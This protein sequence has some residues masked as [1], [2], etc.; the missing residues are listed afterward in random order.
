MTV[1]LFND[2]DPFCC[3]KEIVNYGQGG[4]V[5]VGAVPK[6]YSLHRMPGWGKGS[7]GYH[8]DDGKWEKIYDQDPMSTF[9]GMDFFLISFLDI[10]FVNLITEN[11]NATITSFRYL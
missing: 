9:K 4:A 6:G 2:R 11:E 1:Q 3:F 5:G 7:I 8:A 10:L